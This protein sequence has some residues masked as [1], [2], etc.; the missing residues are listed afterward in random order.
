[1]P[2]GI[3][4]ILQFSIIRTSKLC[5]CKMVSGNSVNSVEERLSTPEWLLVLLASFIGWVLVLAH[6]G[7]EVFLIYN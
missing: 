1:M 6:L 4:S 5:N 3:N 2:D 7:S